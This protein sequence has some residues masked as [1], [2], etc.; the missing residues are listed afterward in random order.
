MV[1]ERLCPVCGYP[2]LFKPPWVGESASDEICPSCGTH[3][4]YDDFDLNEVVRETKHRELRQAWVAGGMQWWS[5][6]R[7]PPSDWVPGSSA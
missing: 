6:S 3:F 5:R 1:D 7:L 4:G 2:D